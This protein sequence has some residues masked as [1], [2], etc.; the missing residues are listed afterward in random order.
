VGPG[1]AQRAPALDEELALLPGRL[2]PRLQESVVRL[3]TWI[4]SFAKA[5]AELAYF[6][7]VHVSRE[8]ARRLTEAAGALQLARETAATEQVLTIQ[9]R[10]PA[11]PDAVTFSVD[12]AMVPLRHG[13]WTEVRTLAVGEVRA[14]TPTGP[15][16][17]TA[18]WSYFSRRA[19]SATFTEQATL[20]LYRRGV[21]TAGRVAAVVD[22]AEW[23]QTFIDVHAPQAVRIL[24]FAHAAERITAIGATV[25]P[26]GPLL[27]SDD[28]T[29][30]LHALKH[31][32][33]AEVLAELGALRDAHPSV[34]E[35]ATHVSYLDKR[36][37]QLH[38]PVFAAQGWPLGSGSV[39]SANK[40]VVE[41][42]LKGAGMHWAVANVNPLLALRNAV[43]NDRW[44]A[45]WTGV[46]A[47]QRRRVRAHRRAQR[48]RRQAARCPMTPALVLPRPSDVPASRP[49]PSARDRRPAATHPWR[50]AW[51]VR[52]Q[53]REASKP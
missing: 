18:N 51:S 29:R 6:T 39:E 12:G 36:R 46:E 10:P 20:E 8:T 31:H 34:A 3:S 41:D 52:Q 43:C 22:G 19:A 48:Q 2:T 15:R 30:L 11:G 7:N 38:Y 37:A 42:R 13:Q 33:P 28:R 21:E 17:Q 14:S 47:A 32:G 26:A 45:T 1:F 40:L 9:P 5:A 44:A 25:G 27:S 35:L 24:D 53:R 23:C 49:H 16:R 50:R 4:P